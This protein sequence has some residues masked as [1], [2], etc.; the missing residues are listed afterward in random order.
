MFPMY[1]FYECPQCQYWIAREGR[2]FSSYAGTVRFSDGRAVS[3]FEET[4]F[5]ELIKCKKC[6]EFLWFNTLMNIADQELINVKI[7][8]SVPMGFAHFLT[9]NENFEAL[10]KG[11]FN[12]PDEEIYIRESIWWAFNNRIRWE[13]RKSEQGLFAEEQ[14]RENWRNNLDSLLRIYDMNYI[15]HRL[16][17]AEIQRNFG[18]F[19]ESMNII[20]TIS[21]EYRS[22]KKAYLQRCRKK[23]QFVFRL[24]KRVRFFHPKDLGLDY[25]ELGV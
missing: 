2:I 7:K 4:D 10:E 16:F 20:S 3:F 14:D 9:L 21:D 15:N 5:P 22:L 6:G 11:A 19:E 1:L 23:D 12:G 17:V 8:Q 18:N 25:V 24:K 13:K